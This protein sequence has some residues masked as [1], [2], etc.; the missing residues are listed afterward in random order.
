METEKVNDMGGAIEV[1]K[2]FIVLLKCI[3]GLEE[4]DFF[5][6]GGKLSPTEFRIVLE[7]I[8]EQRKGGKIIS[9]ELARRV[10]VTRS[11]VSQIVSRLERKQL[12]RRIPSTIDRKIAYVVLSDE[13]VRLFYEHKDRLNCLMDRVVTEYGEERLEKLLAEYGELT[14]VFHR[15]C[16]GN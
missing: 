2:Y 8:L 9:S 6:G 16:D 10:G 11:A 13:A 12:V 14:K 3:K 7:V 1:N 15:V 4:L 5:M